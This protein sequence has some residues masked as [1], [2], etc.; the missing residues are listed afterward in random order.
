[1]AKVSHI[2]VE[3]NTYDVQHL[4]ADTLAEL[5]EDLP[6]YEVNAVLKKYQVKKSN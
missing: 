1:M 6:R 3:G 2:V 4:T 5:V